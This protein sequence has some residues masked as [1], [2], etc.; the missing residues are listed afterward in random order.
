MFFG[1]PDL[2]VPSLRALVA[3]GLTPSLVVGPTDKRRGRGGEPEHAPV[4]AAAEI[5]GIPAMTVEDVNAHGVVAALHG[6]RPDLFVIVAFGQIFSD[7]LLEMPRLGALNLHFSVLPRW[8]GAAP[9]QRAIEAGDEATGVSVQRVA[10]KVDTGGV[11]A[12]RDVVIE[13]G[14][15]TGELRDRLA[16]IGAALVC[17]VVAHCAETD[18]LIEGKDQEEAEATWARKVKKEEGV[19]TWVQHPAAFC[20]KARALHPWPLVHSDLQRDGGKTVRVNF[21]RVA[22]ARAD[23]VD[24]EPGTVMAAGKEGI[25]IACGSGSVLVTELQRS[26]GK[27][28]A[29][30]D[31]LNGL[32]L[33]PGDTFA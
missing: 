25:E 19:A 27:V 33:K 30:A 7:E 13:P 5:L 21:H 14:E 16:D 17:D 9:V 23:G 26:G 12:K 4:V 6:R 11:V 1:T 31:F 28:M 18:H 15:R 24:G 22:P 20:L 29:A 2:A 32:P 10:S 8:R 3:A